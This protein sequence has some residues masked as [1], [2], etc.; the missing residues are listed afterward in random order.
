MAKAVKEIQQTLNWIREQMREADWKLRLEVLELMLGTSERVVA[1]LRNMKEP[2][3]KQVP[4]PVP[5]T[6]VVKRRVNMPAP[7]KLS[8]EPKPDLEPIQPLPPL[9]T[10]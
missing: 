4:V 7:A 8:S 3:Q 2:E 6:Q 5:Q 9:P 1:D 10:S